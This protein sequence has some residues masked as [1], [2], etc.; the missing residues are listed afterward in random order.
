MK[1]ILISF[2][3]MM[4]CGAY[5][6][7]QMPKPTIAADMFDAAASADIAQDGTMIWYSSTDRQSLELYLNP[8]HTWAFVVLVEYPDDFSAV[9]DSILCLNFR[10]P[11][12]KAPW[13]IDTIGLIR[14]GDTKMR[15][16][17]PSIMQFA[18]MIRQIHE[19][20]EERGRPD[21]VKGVLHR[22]SLMENL[23]EAK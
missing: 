1:K 11:S 20:M 12:K 13:G 6:H 2:A 15:L 17:D 7:A 10:R 23:A 18:R 16:L 5:C 3:A 19:R 9:P 14:W 4:I 22:E 21:D 8:A